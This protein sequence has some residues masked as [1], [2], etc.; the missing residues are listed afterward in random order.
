MA[1]APTE[2]HQFGRC[3]LHMEPF[4]MHGLG[5]SDVLPKAVRYQDIA[6]GHLR[7]CANNRSCLGCKQ[8]NLAAA[9]LDDTCRLLQRI[10]TRLK[11]HLCAEEQSTLVSPA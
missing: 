10:S 6:Q 11:E 2:L 9:C 8:R 5:I 1:G 3:V 4:H 7:S